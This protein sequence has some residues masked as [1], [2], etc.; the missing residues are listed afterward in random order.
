MAVCN[1]LLGGL[2]SGRPSEQEREK[3][4]R[5]RQAVLPWREVRRARRGRAARPVPW[6]GAPTSDG[7]G[8]GSARAEEKA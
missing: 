6:P 8:N 3:P 1:Y 4:S 2:F 7:S 5:Q